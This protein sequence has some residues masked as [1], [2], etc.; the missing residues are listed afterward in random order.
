M[1]IGLRLPSN[2]PNAFAE[3]II[4]IGQLAEK[5]GFE[6]CGAMIIS[7][8]PGGQNENRLCCTLPYYPLWVPLQL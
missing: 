6:A 3:Q 8:I 4:R 7:L 5:L 2:G 1:H